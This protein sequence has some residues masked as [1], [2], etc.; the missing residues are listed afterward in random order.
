MMAKT[1]LETI[2][3]Q[4]TFRKTNERLCKYMFNK[5][6]TIKFTVFIRAVDF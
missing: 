6:Q 3:K 5:F 2:L 4:Q 1:R